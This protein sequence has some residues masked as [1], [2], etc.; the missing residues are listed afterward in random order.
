MCHAGEH[1]TYGYTQLHAHLWEIQTL[2]LQRRTRPPTASWPSL[3]CPPPIVQNIVCASLKT[4]LFVPAPT[5]PLCSAPADVR[6]FHWSILEK[7]PPCLFSRRKYWASNRRRIV[8]VVWPMYWKKKLSLRKIRRAYNGYTCSI[9]KVGTIL[10]YLVFSFSSN[11]LKYLP[12]IGIS[13]GVAKER[14]ISKKKN[15]FFY[16]R[17]SHSSVA[18]W[19]VCNWDLMVAWWWFNE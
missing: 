3:L 12:M 9:W 13:L 5:I 2:A 1:V 16:H 17:N 6:Q 11:L 4:R 15:F 18:C 10:S 8:S 7:F 19:S 14:E